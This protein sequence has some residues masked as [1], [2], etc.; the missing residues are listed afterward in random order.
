MSHKIITSNRS[1]SSGFQR[2]ELGGRPPRPRPLP[3]IGMMGGCGGGG[4]FTKPFVCAAAYQA[5]LGSG[6]AVPLV[7]RAVCNG[8][9]SEGG[10]GGG[11]G[12]GTSGKNASGPKRAPRG[13]PGSRT[14][15]S[16]CCVSGRCSLASASKS[17]SS[18]KRELANSNT[19]DVS[20]TALFSGSALGSGFECWTGG[21]GGGAFDLAVKEKGGTGEERVTG[22]RRGANCV[23]ESKSLG[24]FG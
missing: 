20:C 19:S 2:A 24:A 5:A 16:C 11:G 3:R 12:P 23:F 8:R 15:L 21:G 9:G 13:R 18:E 6:F 22:A 4:P 7:D 17:P 10:G 14:R 1:S